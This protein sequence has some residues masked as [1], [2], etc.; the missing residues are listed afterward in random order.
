M[1]AAQDAPV[2]FPQPWHEDAEEQGRVRVWGGRGSA[3][4]PFF[5]AADE[6]R[7]TVLKVGPS[8][9]SRI[10]RGAGVAVINTQSMTCLQGLRC[11][12]VRVGVDMWNCSP[13]Q[14]CLA[15]YA[16]RYLTVL[17]NAVLPGYLPAEAS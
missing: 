15:V 2:T 1:P 13:M 11:G 17:A 6:R 7:R 8:L 10:S 16:Y 4:Q 9:H 3:K 12:G 14:L 5:V